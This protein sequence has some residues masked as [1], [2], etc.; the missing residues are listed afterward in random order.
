MRTHSKWKTLALALPLAVAA[1][2]CILIPEIEERIVELAI[3]HSVVVPFT[4]SGEQN[5]HDKAN[6]V[7][8]TGGVNLKD[9][10]DDN[11]LDASDVKNVKLAGVAYRVTQA[12]AGRSI[13][14]GKVEF[15]RGSNPSPTPPTG[16]PPTSGY[17]QL[18]T[19]FNASAASV[20]DWITVPLDAAGVTAIN[21]LLGELLTEAKGG[22]AVTNKYLT[23][24]V[25]G[26]SVPSNVNTNFKWE[27]RIS[28]TI[29]GTITTDIVN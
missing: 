9:V 18:V 22:A 7:D 1:N 13:T 5:F 11:G 8:A 29:V 14:G 4:A 17:T 21:A 25:Y 20:T 6:T 23:Y 24:H 26:A 15:Q 19:S 27:F 2:G 10:F 12:E 3:G 28:L 16:A